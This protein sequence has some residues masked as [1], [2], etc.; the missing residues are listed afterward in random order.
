MKSKKVGLLRRSLLKLITKLQETSL[1]NDN[2]M[3]IYYFL[4]EIHFF[5]YCGFTLGS[6]ANG[7]DLDKVDLFA[8]AARRHAAMVAS[9]AFKLKAT[10]ETGL[11]VVLIVRF[12]DRYLD[13]YLNQ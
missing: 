6:A 8:L 5:I 11:E 1:K 2:G 4:T 13:K 10:G 9:N 12:A 7:D 3:G